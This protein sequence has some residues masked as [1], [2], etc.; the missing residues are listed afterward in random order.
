MIQIKINFSDIHN[1]VDAAENLQEASQD[2]QSRMVLREL[3]QDILE[4][5]KDDE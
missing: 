5:V 1:R 4:K 3:A 2:K